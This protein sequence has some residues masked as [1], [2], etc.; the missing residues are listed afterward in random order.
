M[1]QK[2]YSSNSLRV[3]NVIPHAR[4]I[5]IKV[6]E[7]VLYWGAFGNPVINLSLLRTQDK[8]VWG[9]TIKKFF[10]NSRGVSVMVDDKTPLFVSL[11]ESGDGFCLK[12]G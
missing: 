10:L 5:I 11:N 12:A 8:R 3:Y 4:D 6:L 2:S 9:N 1:T 7:T